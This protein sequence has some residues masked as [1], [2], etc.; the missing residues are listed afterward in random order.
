MPRFLIVSH[1]HLLLPLAWRL[2]SEGNEVDVVIAKDRFEKA[3]A[4]KL[5]PILKGEQKGKHFEELLTS[6]VEAK[7]WVITDSRGEKHVPWLKGF[8]G[9]PFLLGVLDRDPAVTLPAVLLGA[10]F[11]GEEFSG[12]HLLIEDRGL[13]PD[14]LGPR[15]VGGLTMVS[16]QTWRPEFAAGL[17]LVRDELKSEGFRG[18][19]R[20]G[21]QLLGRGGAPSLVGFQAGWNFLQTH[22]F[23]AQLYEPNLTEV[24][25]GAAPRLPHRYT[26]ALPVSIPP[27]PLRGLYGEKQCNVRPAE[28]PIGPEAVKSGEVFFHDFRVRDGRAFTAGTDGLVG[29]VRASADT[30]WLARQK[31]LRLAQSL[32]LEEMQ[33]RTDVA[34]GVEMALGLLE[35]QGLGV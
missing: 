32:A 9:Y 31:V 29:V 2:K 3:W 27:W 5:D 25:E 23:A 33:Y 28:A 26:I 22:A 10:W 19:V 30:L 14:G 7:A 16:P 8:A 12:E 17:D 18:L 35:S 34:Q 15:V 20:V 4:G 13:W 6:V 21:A 24:V 1:T 11:D